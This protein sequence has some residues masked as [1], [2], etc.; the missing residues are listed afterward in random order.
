MIE[1]GLA[2]LLAECKDNQLRIKMR[3]MI[4][5]SS[6]RG[7]AIEIIDRATSVDC[8]KDVGCW[9]SLR[10]VME[11]VIPCCGCQSMNSNSNDSDCD[12][13]DSTISGSSTVT[14]TIFGYR[15]GRVSFCIQEDPSSPPLLILEF[16]IPTCFLAKEMQHGLLR[17]ALECDK[18]KAS[19]Q[20]GS[21][22]SV[23]VW[24]M[25]CNGRKVGF[26]RKRQ[27]TES[28]LTVLKLMR[29][30]FV[31]AGVLRRL[32]VAKGEEAGELMYMR[33][34]YKRVSGSSDSESFHLINPDGSTRQELSIFFLRS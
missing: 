27:A 18:R 15:K 17:I 32:D 28:D 10:S 24:T 4:D 23:P 22:F 1:K 21:L 25:Y 30:I 20:T 8:Q 19:A 6:D 31:G 3:M 33:A 26:A 11:F 29:S 13:A 14:G 12:D 5:L 9:R 16:G 7:S 34:T 2:C